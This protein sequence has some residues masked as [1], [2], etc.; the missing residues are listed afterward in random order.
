VG[1]QIIRQPDGKLAVFSSFSDTWILL[2]ASPED[3]L[4]YYADKAAEEA[5]E[6]TQE[7]LDKVLTGNPVAAYYQFAMSF[8]EANQLSA[9][10][11]GCAWD[12]D[13]DGWEAYHAKAE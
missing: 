2:D 8:R 3:L 4:E 11:D 10:H 9:E 6:R 12:F 1:H 5:R 7:I 13:A